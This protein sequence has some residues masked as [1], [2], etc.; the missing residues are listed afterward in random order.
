[1]VT[2]HVEDIEFDTSELSGTGEWVEKTI[3][4]EGYRP[5]DIQIILVSDEYLLRI[6]KEF[7]N[8]DWYT[9]IITFNYNSGPVISGDI[10]ISVERTLSNAKHLNIS[11]QKELLRVIIHGV[12]HLCGYDDKTPSD[13]K[14]MTSKEDYYLSLRAV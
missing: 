1:M 14:L 8:H 9:D 3:V 13:K 4:N 12:L 6:N 10:F 7:L 5:G 2:I 11:A